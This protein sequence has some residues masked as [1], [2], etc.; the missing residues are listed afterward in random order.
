MISAVK[1]NFSLTEGDW[2]FLILLILGFIGC[3]IALYFTLQKNRKVKAGKVLKGFI[4][5]FMVG[6]I[7]GIIGWASMESGS[8]W[9]FFLCFLMATGWGMLLTRNMLKN[10]KWSSRES[11]V[12][13]L[14]FII[15]AC[16]MG[17]LGFFLVFNAFNMQGLHSAFTFNAFAAV[18]PWM[19]LKSHDFWGNV[20]EPQYNYWEYDPFGDKPDFDDMQQMNMRVELSPRF[21]PKDA[22]PLLPV[23]AEVIIPIQASLG[24]F[25]QKF[26]MDYNSENSSRIE[27]L[28][29]NGVGEKIAWVFY[30][31]PNPDSKKRQYLD[32][33]LSLFQNDIKIEYT[34]LFAE[35]I[36]KPERNQQK[37]SG[38]IGE[39]RIIGRR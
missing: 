3:F 35:R 19:M 37:D 33:F 34:T 1:N 27:D 28:N 12:P 21:M 24:T 38:S 11:F 10:Q 22:P 25:F 15:C 30:Y 32:P 23:R 7:S 20:P 14:L 4:L 13:E 29:E 5:I 39:I 2:A 36:I 17:G 9:W 6:A 8:G 18:V 31:F 16:C 26:F